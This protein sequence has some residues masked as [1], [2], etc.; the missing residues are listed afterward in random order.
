MGDECHATPLLGAAARAED[1]LLA[2]GWAH[3]WHL[4]SR[5]LIATILRRDAERRRKTL[6]PHPSSFILQ[7]SPAAARAPADRP[8]VQ[9]YL[10]TE[11]FR[12]PV[13]GIVVHA[14][15]P[16]PRIGFFMLESTA[17]SPSTRS[18]CRGS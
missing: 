7:G 11:D 12:R 5:L 2:N 3:S 15:R 10:A 4:R 6:I 1:F 8:D 14:N 16:Q 13:G 17:A 9:R 18:P